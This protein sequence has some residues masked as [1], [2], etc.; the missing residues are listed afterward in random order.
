VLLGEKNAHFI[1]PT[2]H[3]TYFTPDTL[4]YFLKKIGFKIFLWETQGLDLYDWNWYLKE[5]TDYDT[6]LLE[7]N[8]EP[9]QF[10]INASGHGKNL[11]M[12][13]K[14]EKE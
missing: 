4:E 9:F 6:R 11:R 14:K 10:Y 1:W 3:L 5:K 2:H 7:K 8:I 13:C 12:Y